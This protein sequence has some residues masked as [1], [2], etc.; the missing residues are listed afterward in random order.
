MASPNPYAYPDAL[1]SYQACHAYRDEMRRLAIARSSALRLLKAIA[2]ACYA[3]TFF[4][5][6]IP[7]YPS[8]PGKRGP[9]TPASLPSFHQRKGHPLPGWAMPPCRMP[10]PVKYQYSAPEPRASRAPLGWRAVCW[11]GNNARGFSHLP[12]IFPLSLAPFEGEG[13]SW[14]IT[15]TRE[16]A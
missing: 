1:S 12:R 14:G 2:F 15:P 5:S 11:N 4:N 13:G 3:C 8:T 10:S 9:K 7:P 6:L 16:T